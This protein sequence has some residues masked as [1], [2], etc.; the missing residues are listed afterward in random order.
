MK[1]IRRTIGAASTP[2][3][4]ATAEIMSRMLASCDDSLL[5]RRDRALLSLGFAGAFRR[6]ELAA[7]EVADLVE[8]DDGFRVLIRRSKGD[9]EGQG[10][11]SAIPCGYRAH[12]LP[13]SAPPIFGIWHI[14]C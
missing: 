3:L 4:P 7:L 13:A 14:V 6:S 1:G 11:E 8:V 10:A 12:L 9:Q 2:K 5:G